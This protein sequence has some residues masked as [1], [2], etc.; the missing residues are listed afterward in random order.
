M[1]VVEGALREADVLAAVPAASLI[2]GEWRDRGEGD[3]IAV[4]DP[5]TGETLIELP[6][7]SVQDGVAALDAA[8]RAQQAWAETPARDRAEL[9]RDAFEAVIER[10]EEFALL[11]T[12]EMGKPLAEA[13]AEVDYGAEFLR[14]FSEETARIGGRYADHAQNAGRLLT[15]RHPVGPCLLI[16]P[17]NFPLA[18][19]TRKIAP[20]IAA[21]CTMVVK[22]AKQTPLTTLLFARL[23]QD[24]G[25]PPG[26]L[27]VVTSRRAGPLVDALISDGRARKLSFTGST[28][29]GRVLLASCADRVMR[30]SME[31]G[32]NAPLLV[33]D[34]ADLDRAVDGAVLA[35]L[36]NGGESCTAA[37]RI[38]VQDGIADE[39]VAAYAERMAAVQTGRGTGDVELGPMIDETAIE[40][41]Q[42]LVDDAVERG[43][44]LLCG[45]ERIDGPGHFYPATVLDRVPAPA[46]ALREEIFGPVAPVVRFAT[47]DEAIA[48]AN[49]TEYGLVAYAFTRDLDR[50]LRVSDRLDTGMVGINQG[51]V[52]NAAAPF[53]GVKQSGIGREGGFEGL[54]EYLAT[55]Y[56]AI[57]SPPSAPAMGLGG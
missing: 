28:E 48:A 37:N 11:I 7:A 4:E 45:G 16:T 33:F 42:E 25:L 2:G 27:N 36:R 14:W 26:V 35:K 44:E 6:S 19:A 5:A 34:D 8:A 13:R 56:V 22:P 46:R 53:G 29:V 40:K 17:W 32:G 38:Y 41:I 47:E 3:P 57:A 12:L 21:G 15:R 31:L 51:M 30:T 39:F 23:L 20:A 55:K 43:A 9:L 10:R 52:S 24:G 54:D 1:T 49:E 50:A 18:M